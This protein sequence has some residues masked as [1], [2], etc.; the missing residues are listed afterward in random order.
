MSLLPD[1]LGDRVSKRLPDHGGI[2]VEDERSLVLKGTHLANPFEN[3][4]IPYQQLE[5]ANQLLLCETAFSR[6]STPRSKMA[7]IDTM[8]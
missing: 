3:S 7:I 6:G 4:G 1:R 8:T 5:N 2:F